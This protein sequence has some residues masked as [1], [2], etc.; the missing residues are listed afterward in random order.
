MSLDN[1]VGRGLEKA[2]TDAH[3]VARYLT[4]IESKLKDSKNSS[5]SLVSR[6]DLAFESLLQVAVLSLR[7]QRHYIHYIGEASLFARRQ[8]EHLIQILGLNYGTFDLAAAKQGVRKLNCPNLWRDKSP[9]GPERALD[10]YGQLT[11]DVLDYVA[12]LTVFVAQIDGDVQLRR[13]IEESLAWNLRNNHPDDKVLYP[14][15]NRVGAGRSKGT[16]R[17]E[18]S[19]DKPIAGLDP[20]LEV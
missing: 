9:D 15:D 6:F 10:R 19:S 1:L 20:V 8:K 18:I 16:I 12:G 14:D 5:I 11:R 13:H 7:D 3:E 4:M 2:E 17:L